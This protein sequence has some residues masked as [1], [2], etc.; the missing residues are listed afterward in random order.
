MKLPDTLPPPPPLPSWL[1]DQA[2]ESSMESSEVHSE[3]VLPPS[4]SPSRISKILSSKVTY[5]AAVIL[6][7]LGIIACAIGT[8]FFPAYANFIVIGG[9]ILSV[10]A[11]ALVSALLAHGKKE[12]GALHA[13]LQTS[14]AK[15]DQLLDQ[16]N[17]LVDEYNQDS[18]DDEQSI[19]KLTAD[20]NT[21][22]QQYN[23]LLQQ[24]SDLQEDK[25]WSE[26]E[27]ADADAQKISQLEQQNADLVIQNNL[28][29]EENTSLQNN[30]GTLF[31]EKTEEES[32][33]LELSD[34]CKKLQKELAELRA[35]LE[36][37]KSE[38]SDH[39][40]QCDMQTSEISHLKTDLT[41]LQQ[42]MADH[43]RAS[44][45]TQEQLEQQLASQQ[46]LVVK[47][48]EALRTSTEEQL[49]LEALLK[50]AAGSSQDI[51]AEQLLAVTSEAE[52]YKQQLEQLQL[53]IT[54]LQQQLEHQRQ[55][56]QEMQELDIKQEGALKQKLSNLEKDKEDLHAA[57]ETSL[58]KE[59]YLQG[60]L[61]DVEGQVE[62]LKQVLETEGK[63]LLKDIQILDQRLD[64]YRLNQGLI[65]EKS[66]KTVK[67]QHVVTSKSK[68][69]KVIRTTEHPVTSWEDKTV[70]VTMQ[71]FDK[72]ALKKTSGADVDAVSSSTPET[73]PTGPSE[74]KTTS[75]DAKTPA[76]KKPKL[77]SK[78]FRSHKK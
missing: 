52:G 41:H 23:D 1:V 20:Y 5:V 74:D 30:C 72:K 17:E 22:A 62:Q 13:E 66:V 65:L 33:N 45:K 2:R 14:D 16:Y 40:L 54:A 39:K 70:V 44:Q 50:E 37:K 47:T 75:K 27:I 36:K 48:E 26:S 4:S 12:V 67:V 32:R 25:S 28:L 57:L 63:K 9:A 51:T 58:K 60:Q 68:G 73:E 42:K 56:Y 10:I 3:Q 19:E 55:Q 49:K 78:I 21:L 69:Q 76:M 7:L 31:H 8:I 6:A 34:N 71:A 29:Q 11:I 64:V 53:K 15:I 43:Q 46:E 59:K 38:I 77:F 18:V 61:V 24:Y 35:A